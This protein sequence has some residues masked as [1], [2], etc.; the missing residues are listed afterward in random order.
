[1]DLDSVLTARIAKKPKEQIQNAATCFFPA[2][3]ERFLD[4]EMFFNKGKSS[5]TSAS[6]KEFCSQNA[7]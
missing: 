7:F 4:E 3:S 6:P 5:V 2:F 1:M